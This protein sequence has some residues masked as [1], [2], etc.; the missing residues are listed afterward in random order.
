M[1]SFFFNNLEYFGKIGCFSGG[2]WPDWGDGTRAATA[3][4][5][6]I[7]LILLSLSLFTVLLLPKLITWVDPGETGA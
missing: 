7:G 3:G 4:L 5:G 2:L 6:S 1:G